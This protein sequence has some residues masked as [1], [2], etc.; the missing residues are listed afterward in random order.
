MS[1]PSGLA[2]GV[3]GGLSGLAQGITLDEQLENQRLQRQSVLDSIQARKDYQA[4]L[5]QDRQ[6]RLKQQADDAKQRAQDKA[7]AAAEKQRT[8]EVNGLNHLLEVLPKGSA[9]YKSVQKQ[10]T[11][12]YGYTFSDEDLTAT[13]DD[14]LVPS[15]ATAAG[16]AAVRAWQANQA[17]MKV[18]PQEMVSPEEAAAAKALADKQQNDAETARELAVHRQELRDDQAAAA[19]KA[20]QDDPELPA[21]AK[22]YIASLATKHQGNYAAADQEL[23]GAWTNLIAAHPHLSVQ[24]ARQAFDSSFA[25]N[26]VPARLSGNEQIVNNIANKNGLTTAPAGPPPNVGVGTTPTVPPKPAVPVARTPTSQD[27]AALI[28]QVKAEPDPVK[29]AALGVQLKQMTAQIEAAQTPP[30]GGSQ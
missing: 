18:T 1:G 27:L 3:A 15:W 13:P 17:G 8:D 12:K 23:V 5:E 2:L 21:G 16:P 19:T 10:L 11:S 6:D 14:A 24:K 20:Q 22:A 9:A 28:A 26:Q 7:D 4:E 30:G 29:K 25:P